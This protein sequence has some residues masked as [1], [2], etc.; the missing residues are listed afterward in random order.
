MGSIIN[1]VQKGDQIEAGQYMGHFGYGGSSIVL[2][3]EPG[4]DLHFEVG[5][6]PV[7]SPNSPVLMKVRECLGKSGS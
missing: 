7:A 3:F 2:A 6:K 1:A 4:K 5:N